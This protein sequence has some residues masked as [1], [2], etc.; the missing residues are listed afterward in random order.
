MRLLS[1]QRLEDVLPS[2]APRLPVAMNPEDDMFSPLAQRVALIVA[3][4]V[5]ASALVAALWH[6]SSPP[7]AGRTGSPASTTAATP[8]S[9]GA[10]A[11]PGMG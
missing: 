9:S 8:P 1:E 6:D 11:Q 2:D 3:L 7:P 4:A 10:A 5:V